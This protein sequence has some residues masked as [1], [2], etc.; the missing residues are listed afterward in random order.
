MKIQALT[1]VNLCTQP[2]TTAI[3]WPQV[4]AGDILEVSNSIVVENGYTWR[5]IINTPY[6][7]TFQ[8]NEPL[9]PY[10]EVVETEPP[11][12]PEPEPIP[13]PP[14]PQDC[15]LH[16]QHVPETLATGHIVSESVN[17]VVGVGD[18]L[19]CDF[20]FIRKGDNVGVYVV[21]EGVGL[22]DVTIGLKEEL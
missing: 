3:I 7:V 13:D 22:E 18:A 17:T 2:T 8:Q 21:A 20:I 12:I 19:W 9:T 14:P 11:P 10:F 5:N 15:I 6:W 16:I 4:S 1:P